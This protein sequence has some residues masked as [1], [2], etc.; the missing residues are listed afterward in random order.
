MKKIK[1][2]SYVNFTANLKGIP[3]T[4]GYLK[5]K[6]ISKFLF[7]FYPQINSRKQELRIM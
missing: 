2:L 4:S 1:I 5:M 3:I 7:V 6:I